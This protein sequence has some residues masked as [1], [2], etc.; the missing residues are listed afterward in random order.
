MDFVYD[1]PIFTQWTFAPAEPKKKK[2]KKTTRHKNSNPIH[3]GVLKA[4]IQGKRKLV[5]L[6]LQTREAQV[7]SLSSE[8]K[9]DFVNWFQANNTFAN[10]KNSELS[11]K[12]NYPAW[13]Y[14]W[15]TRSK[16]LIKPDHK[17]RHP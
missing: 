14:Q 8:E 2:K 5:N 10:A 9:K 6:F 11:K 13:I 17:K 4:S 16:S 12:E 15:R 1:K 7:F 3:D